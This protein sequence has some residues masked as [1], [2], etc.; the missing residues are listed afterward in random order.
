MCAFVC[1]LSFVLFT[2]NIICAMIASCVGVVVFFNFNFTANLLTL[3]FL[4][5]LF[6]NL[7]PLRKGLV[8]FQIYAL[9]ISFSLK[10]TLV[11]IQ[12]QNSFVLS[13]YLPSTHGYTS[14]EPTTLNTVWSL[15][16]LCII[17]SMV[18]DAYTLKGHTNLLIVPRPALPQIL[19][20]CLW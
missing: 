4:R 9:P 7:Y 1:F 16:L 2:I 17:M 14:A 15:T 8:L 11:Q 10:K 19:D 6:I 18:S 3:F 12:K 13:N 5:L 20:A